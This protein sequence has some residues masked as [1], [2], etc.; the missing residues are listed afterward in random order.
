LRFVGGRPV[1]F[2]TK[3]F[4]S[5]CCEKLQAAGKRVLLIW[6]NASWQISKE[7]RRWL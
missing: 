7:V 3:R 1:S 5:W 6:D 2:I 4:L